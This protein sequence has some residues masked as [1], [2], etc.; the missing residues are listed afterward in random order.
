MG[1]ALRN[2]DVCTVKTVEHTTTQE[3]TRK[4]NLTHYRSQ[5]TECN[6]NERTLLHDDQSDVTHTP[7]EDRRLLWRNRQLE[8]KKK[9]QTTNDHSNTRTTA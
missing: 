8:K 7:P 5:K 3:H 2:D 9:R 4:S 1:A 6:N